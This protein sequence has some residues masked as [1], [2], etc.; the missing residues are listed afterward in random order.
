ALV[1]QSAGARAIVHLASGDG[2][3]DRLTIGA[4]DHQHPTSGGVLGDD[5]DQS[6]AFGEVERVDHRS[7]SASRTAGAIDMFVAMPSPPNGVGWPVQVVNKPPASV[8]TTYGAAA[9]HA[10]NTSSA[11]T[12]A[13]PVATIR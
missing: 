4:G 7:N 6:V 3:L 8:T 5:G 10:A 1:P 13:R 11:I 12:S 9:S 2:T